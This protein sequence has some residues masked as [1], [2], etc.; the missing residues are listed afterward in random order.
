MKRIEPTR[1]AWDAWTFGAPLQQCWSYGEAARALGAR[2][3][4]YAA[5]KTSEPDAIVQV[6]RR[7]GIGYAPVGLHR[8]RPGVAPGARP[9]GPTLIAEPGGWPVS[10]ARQV[11]LRALGEELRAAM[12]KKWRNRLHFAER[13][14]L[15]VHRIAGCPRWLSDAEAAQRSARGYQALPAA[16][17]RAMSTCDPASVVTYAAFVASRPVAGVCILRHSGRCTYH[18]GWTGPEGRSRS[19]HHLLITMAMEDATRVGATVFDLGL[20]DPANDGLRRFKLGTGAELVTLPRMAISW[21][22]K[23]AVRPRASVR[24]RPQA[25]GRAI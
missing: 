5:G 17:L 4:R 16:W 24:A 8:R 21:G 22:P 12:A 13:A 11:A 10:D 15:R 23:A 1:A 7:F 25:S 18:L 6:I 9:P 14:E 20:I 3:E 19:A 2:V